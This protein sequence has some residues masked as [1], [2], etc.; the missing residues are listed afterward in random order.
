MIGGAGV[1]DAVLREEL[2]VLIARHEVLLVFG[3][4]TVGVGFLYASSRR[5]VVSGD[6]QAN[7]ASVGESD[8]LLDESLA[9]RA[10][11]DDRRAVVVLHGAGKDF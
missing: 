3:V 11:P 10:A 4:F 1:L 7:H 2:A 5:R 9:E 6:G 8:L